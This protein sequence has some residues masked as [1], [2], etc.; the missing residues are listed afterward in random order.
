MIILQ[1]TEDIIHCFWETSIPLSLGE[2]IFL[3]LRELCRSAKMM[4]PFF[5][6]FRPLECGWSE[7]N[8]WKRP[9][10]FNDPENKANKGEIRRPCWNKTGNAWA[11]EKS[12][13]K[14]AQPWSGRVLRVFTM[15]E[16]N[17]IPEEG[18][19][20]QVSWKSA[21]WQVLWEEEVGGF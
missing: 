4:A 18:S 3:Q 8:S 5:H 2:C 9:E 21:G 16:I 1:F 14:K 13:T 6:W 12:K 11:Q 17:K 15:L 7:C 10:L 19:S 20:F